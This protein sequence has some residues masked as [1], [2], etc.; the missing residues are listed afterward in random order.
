[1]WLPEG[2]WYEEATGTMLTGGKTY[3]RIMA[4]D[5]YPAYIKAGSV[6]PY[7]QSSVG[8][9]RS[10]AAPLSISI[11]PG[12][13]GE[14]ELYEDAGD[15]DRYDG[16]Y[17]YT[18]IRSIRNGDTLTVGILPRKGSYDGMPE[19]RETEIKIHS[20]LRPQKV[21]IDGKTADYTFLP[22]ELA[23][24]VNLGQR[25]CDT[26]SE[27]RI[28]FPADATIA[29]GTMGDMRR[30][31]KTFGRLKDR[32][33]DLEVTEEFGP[34][35]VIAEALGYQPQNERQ[36]I[37]SFKE[38]HSRLKEIVDKQPMPEETRRWFLSQFPRKR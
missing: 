4:M 25:R 20:T 11:Y 37:D 6:I 27:I 3:E 12:G 9:L 17:A 13:E 28:D 15:D 21:T 18:P 24:V 31:V 22:D 7:H 38:K 26:G 35:C 19:S 8:N 14:F 1:V 29:D 30:F 10:N 16:E 34:M 23:V 5:E 32:Y 33:A 2:E 36:L